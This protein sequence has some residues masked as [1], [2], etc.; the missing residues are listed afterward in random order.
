MFFKSTMNK[1]C[2][3][4]SVVLSGNNIDFVHETKYLGVIINSSMKTCSDVVRQSGK[5]YAQ[6]NKL[7]HNFRYCT[8]D[9]RCSS[10]FV[11]ICTVALFGLTPLP[12]A[13][14]KLK[15]SYNSALCN[16]LLIKKPYNAS[17]VFFL[18]TNYFALAFIGLQIVSVKIQI[19][20]FYKEDLLTYIIIIIIYN[21]KSL[22][23][24]VLMGNFIIL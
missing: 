7:L 17:M 21:F 19:P 11:Q 10:H 13:L 24:Y 14:K 23:F 15:T 4:V 2:D 18:F 5:F 12:L 22:L 6:A 20:F 9:V 3:N 8:N 16:L 1:L